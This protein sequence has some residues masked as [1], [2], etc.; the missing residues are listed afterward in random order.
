MNIKK[1]LRILPRLLK[2]IK[3]SKSIKKFDQQSDVYFKSG[4]NNLDNGWSKTSIDE[5]LESPGISE[6]MRNSELHRKPDIGKKIYYN[7]NIPDFMWTAILKSK[8]IT[9]IAK[10]YIGPEARLDDLYIKTIV[11]GLESGAEGWHDDN[12]GYRLK[13]FM[14]F[15]VEGTPSN[16]L[17]IPHARPNLYKIE[18]KEEVKRMLGSPVKI[19]RDSEIQVNY[20]A[21][22]CLIFDTNL[23]H[24]GDYSAGPGIRYCLVAEFIHRKKADALRKYSPCGPGQSAMQ[25]II[26]IRDKDLLLQHPLIDDSI[27]EVF[28][29]NFKYGYKDCKKSIPKD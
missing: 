9:D 11:D 7:W 14:V 26:P 27:L 19:K 10:G 20:L 4:K 21:G 5:I 16:T 6:I 2:R 1:I 29:D 3:L 23:R 28:G 24:R 13:V 12:V 8:L 25:I 22:D 17:L 18:I 15:D